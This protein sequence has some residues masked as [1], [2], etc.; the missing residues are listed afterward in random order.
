MSDQLLH[1]LKVALAA[2]LSAANRG[3]LSKEQVQAVHDQ[4]DR[5]EY[6]VKRLEMDAAGT[7]GKPQTP[8]KQR[9][10]TFKRDENQ[11]RVGVFVY[12]KRVGNVRDEGSLL[13]F[14]SGGTSQSF[15]TKRKLYDWVRDR[16]AKPL[17]NANGSSQH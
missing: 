10:V 3:E 13:L 7:P 1:D 6:Q 9:P 12:G 8:F 15:T 14:E 5:L 11:D 17:E 16:Y 4:V 2:A